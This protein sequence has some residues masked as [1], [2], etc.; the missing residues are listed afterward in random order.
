MLYDISLS[1]IFKLKC[2]HCLKKRH[3]P[4]IPTTIQYLFKLKTCCK[5]QYSLLSFLIETL[6]LLSFSLLYIF[7][8]TRYIF[9]FLIFVSAL[10]GSVYTDL[11]AFLIS[12]FFSIFLLPVAFLLCWQNFLPTSISE[13]IIGASCSYFFLW[14]INSIFKKIKNKDGIGEGDFELLAL[15]GAFTGPIGA[16]FSLSIA[17]IVGSAFG[18]LQLYFSKK[19]SDSLYIP[20][21]PFLA[22]GAFSYIL[23][24]Q[25]NYF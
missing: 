4:L 21:G 3:Y 18:I 8:S 2:V 20:F 24:L 23:L 10:L 5:K 19:N 13:S 7:I 6:T 9:G 16:W 11:S 12:R 15:I 25:T 17:S 1:H 14:T 22:L